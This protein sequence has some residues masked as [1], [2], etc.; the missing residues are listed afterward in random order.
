MTQ[1]YSSFFVNT[2]TDRI[3]LEKDHWV[4]IKAE[5]SIGDWERYEGSMLQ[6]IAEES[7]ANNSNRAMRRRA[8]RQNNKAPEIRM[9]AGLLELLEINIQAWSFEDVPLSRTNISQLRNVHA[10]TVLEAIQ[11]RN[12]DNP[13]EVKTTSEEVST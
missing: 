6:I 11:E 5:M 9:N 12:P 10:N 8:Q 2:G 7:A 1:Q 3:P 13:L 4:D